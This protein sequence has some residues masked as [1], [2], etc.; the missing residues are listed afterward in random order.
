M[1]AVCAQAELQCAAKREKLR[2]QVQDAM[3]L[4]KQ[5]EAVR[6]HRQ[7]IFVRAKHAIPGSRVQHSQSAR[8]DS[9]HFESFDSSVSF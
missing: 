7:S 1:M 9:A 8:N 3:A 5:K 2:Q 4:K 6:A